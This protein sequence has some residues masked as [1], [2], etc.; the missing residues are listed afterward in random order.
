MVTTFFNYH[1]F[2]STVSPYVHQKLVRVV[3]TVI[4]PRAAIS[5]ITKHTLSFS[6]KEHFLPRLEF[7]TYW[8]HEKTYNSPIYVLYE[9]L[10]TLLY[11]V[12]RLD[13]DTWDSTDSIENR[14][15]IIYYHNYYYVY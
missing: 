2:N 3:F 11:T 9:M 10:I 7:S 12:G 13:C 5:S 8:I 15:K 6:W 14:A 4:L 1:V